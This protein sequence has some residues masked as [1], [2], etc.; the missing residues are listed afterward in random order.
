MAFRLTEP[1]DFRLLE[2]GVSRR[3]LEGAGGGGGP[4]V[5]SD[6]PAVGGVAGGTV[7][8]LAGSG[9]TGATSVTFGGTA[10]PSFTVDS[11]SQITVVSPAHAAGVVQIV[12][13]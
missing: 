1:G 7:V 9:F 4:T 12:V 2:D 13:T 11:D 8:V 6:V 5:S 3:L 10:A